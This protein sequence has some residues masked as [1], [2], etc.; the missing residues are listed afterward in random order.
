MLTGRE[1][2][3][4]IEKARALKGVTRTELAAYFGVRHESTY[5][6]TNHGRIAKKH[7]PRL[8]DYFSDVVGPSHWG[9][10]APLSPSQPLRIDPEIL[11]SAFGAARYAAGKLN[12]VFDI[13]TLAPVIAFAY[14]E[15]GMTNGTLTEPESAAY[16][17]K[18]LEW[19]KGELSDE[20]RGRSAEGGTGSHIEDAGA[21]TQVGSGA[22]G[23]QH[24]VRKG[25][26]AAP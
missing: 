7:L 15:R 4:A 9:L 24:R 10:D 11:R 8:F 26:S 19:L 20:N 23:R 13:D 6:W 16:Y 17:E 22:A 25:H 18:V 1:L 5:D 3:E 14:N 2:G 21:G 12:L